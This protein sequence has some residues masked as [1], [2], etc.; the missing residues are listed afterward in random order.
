MDNK[1][2]NIN[3]NDDV[4]VVMEVLAPVPD[5]FVAPDFNSFVSMG[6]IDNLDSFN[7]NTETQN[8]MSIYS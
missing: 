8:T 6:G 3:D 1:D 5:D 7:A 4:E 2:T